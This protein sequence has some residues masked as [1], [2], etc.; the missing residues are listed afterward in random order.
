[1]LPI[2]VDVHFQYRYRPHDDAIEWFYSLGFKVH[3]HPSTNDYNPP[4]LKKFEDGRFDGAYTSHGWRPIA[5][6]FYDDCGEDCRKWRKV[7]CADFQLTGDGVKEAYEA[8]WGPLKEVPNDDEEDEDVEADIWTRRKTMVD[9]VRVLLA[10]VG[11]G[12]DIA[13]DDEEEDQPS[14]EF[15]LEGLNDRWFAKGVRAA[16]GLQL[17]NDLADATRDQKERQD[18]A[19]ETNYDSE[20]ASEEWVVS[21]EDS[22]DCDDSDF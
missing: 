7:E 22:G 19:K 1:M 21:D 17:E 20:Y 15:T 10:A 16:C 4:E 6:G 13:V 9:T 12:Y 8:L 18:E 11:I 2:Y 5:Y 3:K 14:C